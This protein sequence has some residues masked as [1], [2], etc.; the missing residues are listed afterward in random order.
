M[1]TE[2]VKLEVMLP[3]NRDDCRFK[4]QGPK[5]AP[6]YLTRT[7]QLTDSSP[8]HLSGI[9]RILPSDYVAKP[10]SSESAPDIEDGEIDFGT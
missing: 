6:F 10:Q 1:K 2:Q 7:R 9:M 8:L 4:I 3:D 5:Y